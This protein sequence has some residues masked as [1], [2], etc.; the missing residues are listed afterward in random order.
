[1]TRDLSLKIHYGSW[2]L[3]TGASDGIGQEFAKELARLGFNLVLSARRQDRLAALATDLERAHSIRVETIAADLSDPA[4]P[5]A[6]ID[7]TSSL[8]IGLLVAAAGFGTSGPFIENSLESELN[9]LDVNCRAVLALTHSF[10]QRF[11]SRGRGGIVLMSSLVA[12]QGVRGAANYAAT[13]AYI[14]TLAEG[15]RAELRPSGVDIIAC[16]PGPVRSGFGARAG[17]TMTLAASPS[18]VAA[19]T[20]R[21]LGRKTTVRPGFLSKALELWLWP[22]PRRSRTRIMSA[23]MKSMTKNRYERKKPQT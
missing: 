12:F 9:M 16:A 10:A 4:A 17:M 11:A 2:A 22:L 6:I 5:A 8:D 7:K 1:M 23:I 20:L 21:G 15:L 18:S 19:E 3:V 13:K 14:Q